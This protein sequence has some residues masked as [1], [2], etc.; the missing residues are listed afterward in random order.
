MQKIYFKKDGQIQ[1]L[2]YSNKNKRIYALTNDYKH[3]QPK[4]I[5]L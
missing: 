4:V 5:A 2:N 3:L 1:N